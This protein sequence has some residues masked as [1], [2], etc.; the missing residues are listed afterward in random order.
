M[1]QN[2]SACWNEIV[3]KTYYMDYAMI[4]GWRVVVAV[5]AVRVVLL[6]IEVVDAALVVSLVDVGGRVVALVVT[7]S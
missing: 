2:Q 4:T 6:A 3:D 7:T 1:T 5:V